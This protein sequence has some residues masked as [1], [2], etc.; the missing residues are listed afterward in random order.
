[1]RSSTE[2]PGATGAHG[3]ARPSAEAAL[4]E[5]IEELSFLRTLNDRLARASDFAS[6][7]RTLVDLIS[8]EGW[9]HAVAYL[10]VDPQRRICR[11][12]A[13]AP[14]RSR[15]EVSA[16]FRTTVGPFARLLAQHDVVTI[17]DDRPPPWLGEPT[18]G[19]VL[20]GARMLVR[21]SPTGLLL[22]YTAGDRLAQEEQR[23]LLAI[24]AT[25]AALALD[26]ARADAREEF[27]AMLRHDINNPV[28][29]ALGCAELIVQH[30][31]PT[32]DAE[33]LRFARSVVESLGAVTDL[34]SNYLHMSAIDRGMPC[35]RIEEIDLAEIAT[36]VVDQF[37]PSA[38]EKGLSVSFRGACPSAW[39][40]R[41]QLERV[42][43][44]LV[45]NAVK[46]TPRGGAIEVAVS[47]DTQGAT[48]R[49]RDTGYGVGAD[50]LPRLFTK[51]ARFHLDSGIPGT[52]LGLYI[53]KGIVEA[54]GG[55]ID[56]SSEPGR[57]TTFS[58]RIPAR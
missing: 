8:D 57:G 39:G 12:E 21:D 40:D 3:G 13:V 35:L 4:L 30:L 26:V 7:C 42:I 41:R 49:V 15:A 52:G 29:V 53:S 55:R 48:L 28:T 32:H 43:T 22:V 37:R 31:Q 50:D 5:K 1:M 34:V 6:A 36:A 33:L 56:V 18:P 20:M 14:S 19:G 47:R 58:V 16:E 11:L 24:T 38:A 9:A 2:S 46:Y 54:H 51:Y 25:S 10:S 23:R 44:N 17:L 27:L 45:S